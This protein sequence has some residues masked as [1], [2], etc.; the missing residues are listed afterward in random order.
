MVRFIIVFLLFFGKSALG[1]ENSGFGK[2][3]FWYN[4]SDPWSMFM[5]TEGPLFILYDNGKVLF[6]RNGHYNMT[7]LVQKEMSDLV[8]QLDITDTM[9]KRSRHYNA[10]NPD[11]HG[12][13]IAT[14][15]PSYIV[16][17]QNDTLVRV[18]VYGYISKKEYRKRFPEQ[19]L[20]IH[21]FVVNFDSENSTEWI[22]EKIEVLLSDYRNSPE[23]PIVWPKDWP[24]LSSSET[25]IGDYVTSIFLDR[26]NLSQLNRLIRLRKEK[27]AV[28][29]SGR[30]FFIGY[31]YP[32]PG[33]Y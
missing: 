17:V 23:I 18:S 10:T 20:N 31:R 33:L 30:K 15:N 27:Q 9:F 6:W 25:R 29:I 16:S 26:K 24:D 13:L 28:L 19:V 4:V 7:Q 12:E 14:D 2:P 22:P 8:D 11:P 32:I 3:I 1:Q 21:N 5:G